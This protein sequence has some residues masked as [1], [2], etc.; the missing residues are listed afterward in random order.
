MLEVLRV[1]FPLMIC[2]GGVTLSIEGDKHNS[3]GTT[4]KYL[5]VHFFLFQSVSS[6]WE[7]FDDLLG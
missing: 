1:F 4:E 5:S 6:G 2:Q 3:S 7:L